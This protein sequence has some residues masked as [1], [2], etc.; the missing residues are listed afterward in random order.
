MKRSWL[1]TLLLTIGCN[2]RTELLLGVATDLKAPDVLDR[3]HLE[4]KQSDKTTVEID[5]DISGSSTEPFNLPG[6]FGLVSENGS[7]HVDLLLTGFKGEQALLTRH[8]ALNLVE[9]ETLFFRMG[10]TAGCVGRD[11]CPENWS[12]VEGVCR[13]VNVDSKRLPGWDPDLVNELTCAG[14]INYIDTGTGMEMPVA[15]GA[16][17]CPNSQCYEG[18]CLKPPQETSGTRTVSGSRV[19]TYVQQNGVRKAV[20]EDLTGFAISAI[21]PD[22]NGGAR[23]IDGVGNANGTFTIE[24]V[25]RG[26]YYLKFGTSYFYVE[27]DA[28][29]FGYVELG[30]ENGVAPQS[31]ATTTM[32]VN[33][34]GLAP[35]QAGDTIQAF[36]P[37]A[38]AW[39]F[40]IEYQTAVTDGTTSLSNYM[41][42][43]D[44]G[45]GRLVQNDPWAMIQLAAATTA[46]GDTYRA[47]SRMLTP[48]PFNE[49][50]GGNTSISGTFLPIPQTLTSTFDVRTTEWEAAVGF[51]GTSADLLGPSTTLYDNGVFVDVAFEPGGG[52]YGFFAPTI[53]VM[54]AYV[55][56][57]ANK[58][59]A[60]VSYGSPTIGNY[61]W[62][63]V[64]HTQLF[65]EQTYRVPGATTDRYFYVGI[66]DTRLVT[67]PTMTLTPSLGPVLAPKIAG[68]NLLQPQSG[69]GETPRLSWDPPALGV[70]TQYE[71][72]IYELRLNGTATAQSFVAALFVADPAITI[73]SGLLSA[74][75][76]YVVGITATNAGNLAAPYRQRFPDTYASI[77]SGM[78]QP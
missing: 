39:W 3:V 64:V 66:N 52:A 68:R 1:L 56:Q 41:F 38:N 33:A 69:V 74:G 34:T 6:S 27:G 65:F 35:W 45:R 15:D 2:S 62:T 47:A 11:D 20:P 48:A 40:Y 26:F 46:G 23:T 18:T 4:V 25:P 19:V 43:R 51:N 37:D 44:S 55:A 36:A 31:P 63:R 58:T 72:D 60:G 42:S 57:G 7:T 10:L 12:C 32:T 22:G 61:P 16:N 53:D 50:D 13:D 5:W 75:G 54:L 67:G 70:A 78:I 30:R 17:D 77:L 28:I 24:N 76:Y 71:V 29:D 49:V 9:D 8:A 59:L 14:G 73:P 21:I